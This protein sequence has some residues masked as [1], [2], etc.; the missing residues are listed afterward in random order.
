MK[1]WTNEEW[2]ALQAKCGRKVSLG[3]TRPFTCLLYKKDTLICG[4]ISGVDV[5]DA[6]T[7]CRGNLVRKNIIKMLDKAMIS[8][9]QKGNIKAARD[10]L[11]AKK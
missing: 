4:G 7:N 6:I 1:N 2:I 3:D 9:Q 10:I 5:D 8:G 11:K